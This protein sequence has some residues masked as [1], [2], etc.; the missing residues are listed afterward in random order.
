MV[1]YKG[2]TAVMYCGQDISQPQF[3]GEAW[4]L[5]NMAATKAKEPQ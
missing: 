3:H 5:S 1:D 4:L 2:W